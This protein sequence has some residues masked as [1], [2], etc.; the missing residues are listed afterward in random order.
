M[1]P[2]ATPSAVSI[3]IGSALLAVAIGLAGCKSGAGYR[4]VPLSVGI[5]PLAP[6]Q[7][8]AP[9]RPPRQM[10]AWIHPHEDRSQGALI[11]GHW[12]FV[13]LGDGSWYFEDE[14]EREPQADAELSPDERRAALGVLS[15]PADA[16]LPYR[17][18]EEKRP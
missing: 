13:L 4:P 8:V 3:Y 2:R 7:P 1:T 15:V 5:D 10:A 11:G 12:I 16:T 6:P 9:W 14:A 18:K 17:L